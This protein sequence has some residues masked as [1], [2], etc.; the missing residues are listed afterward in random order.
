MRTPATLALA[1]IL[2]VGLAAC[3]SGSFTSAA[4]NNGAALCT[5]TVSWRPLGT[6]EP[7]FSYDPTLIQGRIEQSLAA[8]FASNGEQF[9]ITD[10]AP[11]VFQ[12]EHSRCVPTQPSLNDWLSAMEQVLG[13]GTELHISIV[14]PNSLRGG[15]VD[16]LSARMIEWDRK[17]LGIALDD[18]EP[19]TTAGPNGNGRCIL[20]AS[21]ELGGDDPVAVMS[22]LLHALL[23]ERSEGDYDYVVSY[24]YRLVD[25]VGP[26]YDVD[27]SSLAFSAFGDCEEAMARSIAFLDN[28]IPRMDPEENDVIYRFF[29]LEQ[30][31]NL[32]RDDAMDA[33]IAGTLIPE[34]PTN[35]D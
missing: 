11:F 28:S 14:S 27:Y 19:E 16:D 34:G 8:T 24:N 18:F 17:Y 29:T 9:R 20:F 25:R 4:S 10:R 21:I 31:A 32:T 30:T 35:A 22:E 12:F 26:P 2:A 15:T 7:L 6:T 33:L 13:D 23:V 5:T 1:M 3:D